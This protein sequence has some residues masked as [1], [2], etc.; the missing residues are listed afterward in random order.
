MPSTSSLVRSATIFTKP[1]VS[2]D[3]FARPR[4]PNGKAPTR[5]SNPRSFASRSVRP[6]LPISGSQYVQPAASLGRN[7]PF[8]GGYM[9]ELRMAGRAQRN[10]VAHGRNAWHGGLVRRVDRDVAL[11]DLQ[12]HS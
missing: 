4:T 6:T 2:P 3:I 8:G 1:S 11:L 5:T 12:P 7:D 9:R 10:D